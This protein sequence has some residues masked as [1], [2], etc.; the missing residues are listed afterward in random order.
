MALV[1]FEASL[2]P[3]CG[4]PTWL[5]CDEDTPYRPPTSVKCFPCSYLEDAQRAAAKE[6]GEDESLASYRWSIQQATEA[7][8]AGDE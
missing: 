7:D 8:L 2:C 5:A 3:G 1:Q 6:A 4:H